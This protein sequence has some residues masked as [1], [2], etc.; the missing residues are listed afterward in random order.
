VYQGAP[1]GQVSLGL[2]PRTKDALLP[3]ILPSAFF[4]LPLDAELDL[5]TGIARISAPRRTE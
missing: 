1:E 3:S 4:L 5:E 2:E